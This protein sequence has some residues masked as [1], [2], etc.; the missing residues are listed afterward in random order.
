MGERRYS[1]K[2]DAILKLIQSTKSHPRAQWVY[3]QLKPELPDLSLG[4]VYRNIKLLIKEGELASI[5]V[6]DGEEH[7]DGIAE[8]HSHVICRRC[9][10]IRDLPERTEAE[11][12]IRLPVEIPG[13]AVDLRNTVFY[14]LC[15][16]CLESAAL[17][18]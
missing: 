2:R 16:G 10:T 5:G 17:G 18:R 9:G 6:V 12:Q 14:G 8:P 3:D 7:F 11:L 13:F 1:K 4:T 15:T